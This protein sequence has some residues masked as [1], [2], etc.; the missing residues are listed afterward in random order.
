M[1]KQYSQLYLDAR[2]ALLLTEDPQMAGM[3]ARTLLCHV[4]GKTQ[5]AILADRDLYASEVICAAMDAGVKRLINGEPLAYVL[6][7]W[8]FYGLNLYVN[9]HV[10][11]PRQ[12]TEILVEE[13]LKEL[14]DGM[15]ILDMCTGSGC[16]LISLLHYSNWCKGVGVD[17]SSAAL[18][19]AKENANKLLPE[20][21]LAKVILMT[22]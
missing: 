7:E 5:E 1:V 6:G 18:A 13:V 15:R 19:V 4:S 22:K 8:E 3:M 11:I 17:I 2:R 21:Y 20:Y 12:D 16:I 10:L 14:H 9:E